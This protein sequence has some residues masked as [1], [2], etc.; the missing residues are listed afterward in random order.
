MVDTHCHLNFKAFDHDLS[1]VVRRAKEK[2]VEK[3]IVPGTDLESSKKA[4]D[5]AQTYPGCYAAIGIHPHHAQDPNLIINDQLQQKLADLL[6][7]GSHKV[8]AIGEIGL[9]Y[10]WYPEPKKQPRLEKVFQHMLDLA[11]EF[12]LPVILHTRKAEQECFDIVTSSGIKDVVF[13]CYAGNLTLAQKIIDQDYYISVGT[14]L[15]RSKNAKKI[16]KISPLEQLLTETDAPF[17][18]PYPGKQNVPQN[19]GFVLEEMSKLRGFPVGEI[20]KVIE[21]NCRRLFR[22]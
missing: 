7:Q 17:L 10:H 3:L 19:V 12:N 20:D 9:D 18:S 4:I 16:A 1:D 2:G 5:I 21:G 13:H 11:K 8:V 6:K 14:N 15:L 22:I